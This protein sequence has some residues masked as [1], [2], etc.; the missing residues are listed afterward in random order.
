MEM[1]HSMLRI[2]LPFIFENEV[3]VM[4]EL[5][6]SGER[7]STLH[8]EVSAPPIQEATVRFGSLGSFVCESHFRV[9][10]LRARWCPKLRQKVCPACA[11]HGARLH[12]AVPETESKSVCGKSFEVD[13]RQA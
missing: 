6:V 2:A 13:D 12:A 8:L 11:R 10:Y 3:T 5:F 7:Q 4:T 1:I 9:H